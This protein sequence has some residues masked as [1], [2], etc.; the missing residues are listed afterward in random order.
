MKILIYMGCL[1][2]LISI[3]ESRRQKF[4][5]SGKQRPRGHRHHIFKNANPSKTS[6]NRKTTQVTKIVTVSDNGKET[7]KTFNHHN[8][9]INNGDWNP[10]NHPSINHHQ[11][12]KDVKKYSNY[13]QTIHDYDHQTDHNPHNQNWVQEIDIHPPNPYPDRSYPTNTYFNPHHAHPHPPP[14]SMYETPYHPWNL[15]KNEEYTTQCCKTFNV[16]TSDTSNDIIR[17][18]TKD[19]IF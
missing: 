12:H 15:P 18:N 10:P 4:V 14:D 13:D 1:L 11:N 7:V 5:K 17:G 9:K 3:A 8:Q 16:S 6:K 19:Y 2:V